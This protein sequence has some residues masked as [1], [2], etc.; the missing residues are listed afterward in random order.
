MKVS[1]SSILLCMLLVATTIQLGR[2]L[3]EHRRLAQYVAY[4]EKRNSEIPPHRL[5][6][7]KL[8]IGLYENALS[9][10]SPR[11]LLELARQRYAAL[12]ARR[13][14]LEVAP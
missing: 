11:E 2:K 4:L 12:V 7:L 5:Y 13:D 9:A 6:E 1:I 8:K 10:E 3:Y 14:A